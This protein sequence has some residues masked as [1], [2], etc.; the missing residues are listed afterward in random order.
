MN[1]AT[2]P[3]PAFIRRRTRVLDGE[4]DFVFDY[5]NNMNIDSVS[6]DKVINVPFCYQSKASGINVQDDIPVIWYRRFFPM[7]KE[8]GHVLL[9]F[10]AVDYFASVYINGSLA[11]SHKGGFSAFKLDITDYVQDGE[12]EI[13]VRCEDSLSTSHIRGKQ[14]WKGCLFGCWY[15]PTSGIWQ[16]VWVEEIS[17]DLYIRECLI[18]PNI[19]ENRAD[20]HVSI[21]S[22]SDMEINAELSIDNSVLGHL[23]IPVRCGEGCAS[24][25]FNDR[26][27][28][29]DEYQWSLEK[30]NLIDVRLN[31]G[32][33]EVFVY[34]GMRN[35][36]IKENGIY[37]NHHRLYQRLILDQGYWPDS[38]MTP[39]AG[40]DLE[41]DII[42][43]IRMGFN[44]A[45]KHQKLEDPRYYYY[46]D[47]LGFLVWGELPS[48]Y[49]YSP[50]T[51]IDVISELDSYIRNCFNHPSLIA[52]VPL[53]ES[54][55]VSNIVSD[56]RQQAFAEALANYAKAMDGTRFVSSN[57][58]WEQ[59]A[60]SDILAVHDY[61]VI[62][63]WLG[64]SEVMAEKGI[65]DARR[66]YA[67]SEK[68]SG[69]PIILT[70]FGGIAFS[71]GR[72]DTWGYNGKVEDAKAYKSRLD[73]LLQQVKADRALA[74]F[75]YTQL[76][77]VIQE[78]NGLL[79]ADRRPKID[80]KDL[81]QFF[82]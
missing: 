70:E 54:W 13:V 14:S 24:F 47:K 78:T 49:C 44:G 9:C 74:G 56:R 62:P 63:E 10:G 3:D 55:G 30:P 29:R 23:N 81:Y 34:F 37:L 58:G 27:I 2:Y 72:D 77:D 50:H 73:K 45:R 32:G 42:L 6:F 68:Y 7:E 51:S 33:D 46:A 36:E 35:I 69:Q 20:F 19:D 76:T 31:C 1:K 53:N 17:S 26:D 15:T 75:C 8:K 28:L 43:S 40:E 4:W 82:S 12:N 64:A 59:T 52:W 39:P 79:T 25:I 16:S 80:L 61:A 66:L 21:S 57:D 22:D 65:A 60:G 48:R 38:L 18:T 71:D 11:G 41:K 67:G 5:K